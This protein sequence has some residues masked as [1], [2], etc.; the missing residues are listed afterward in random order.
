[1]ISRGRPRKFGP[2]IT[3]SVTAQDYDTLAALAERDE[4]S[5][6]WVVRRA[7]DDYLEQNRDTVDRQLP[8]R[9]LQARERGRVG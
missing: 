6:S 3:V 5:V 7:I 1:M 4:V 2:R 8:L 9:I